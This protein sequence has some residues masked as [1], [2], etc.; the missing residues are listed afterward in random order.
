[1]L[2]IQNAA[3]LRP[4]RVSPNTSCFQRQTCHYITVSCYAGWACTGI[5]YTYTF[6]RQMTAM[7]ET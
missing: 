5:H 6:I 2:S 1:M 4:V 7:K 3:H